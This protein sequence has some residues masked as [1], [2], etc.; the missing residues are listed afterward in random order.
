MSCRFKSQ[1]TMKLVEKLLIVVALLL[2]SDVYGQTKTPVKFCVPNGDVYPFFLDVNAD[3]T[4]TN[5][6]IIKA[7][8]EREPLQKAELDYVHRPWKR[9]NIELKSGAIDLI[10]G[11][12]AAERD[13]AGVYPNELGFNLADMVFSTADVCF[14]SIKGPQMDKARE[15]MAGKAP[16]NVG[17]EAGFSQKHE[18]N[19]YPEWLVIYNH[20]E[21]YRLL[22]KGRVDAIVQVCAMDQ[23][24]IATKAENAGFQDFVTLYPP[25]LSNPAYVVFSHLFVEKNPE[26]AKTILEEIQKVDK[27]QIYSRY[28]SNNLSE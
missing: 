23:F 16:F 4:G 18:P 22:Q 20:L 11:G 8:F 3:I 17:V 6:D 7:A 25:Y 2:C 24:P 10:I 1:W 15:G 9:C 26:L 21:K 14:V 13:Q 28:K 27:Q 12:Y 19:I 5:P